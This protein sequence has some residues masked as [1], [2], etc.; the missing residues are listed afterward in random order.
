MFNLN[1]FLRSSLMGT[2]S[3]ASPSK[4]YAFSTNYHACIAMPTWP[5]CVPMKVA[6][7][8]TFFNLFVAWS[9]RDILI[10]ANMHLMVYEHYTFHLSI[11][12]WSVLKKCCKISGDLAWHIQC[13]ARSCKLRNIGM[14]WVTACA[15]W[16]IELRR[17]ITSVLH[18][19]AELFSHATLCCQWY[20]QVGDISISPDWHQYIHLHVRII[21][22]NILATQRSM[23]ENAFLM[24]F[25]EICHMEFSPTR[26]KILPS[27]LCGSGQN[28]VSLWEKTA[29]LLENHVK[30]ISS[31]QC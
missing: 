8:C 31:L 29:S 5:R 7:W 10:P 1:F 28:T 15:C 17:W 27:P 12:S 21:I 2:T 3:R 24:V 11:V 30:C 6:L 13:A 16:R 26:H 9:N 20:E 14:G 4:S 25:Q 23:G 18:G 19:W 22:D